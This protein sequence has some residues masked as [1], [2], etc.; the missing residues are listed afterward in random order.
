MNL[1]LF[2]ADTTPDAARVHLEIIRRLS[3][4]RRLELACEMSNNLREVSVSGVR[5]RHLEYSDEQVRFA[6]ARLMLGDEL[7]R[8]VHPGIEIAV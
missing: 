8:K 2:P 7:F 3:P 4:E 5:S 6:V 1:E